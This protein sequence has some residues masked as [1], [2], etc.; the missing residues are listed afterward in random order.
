ML[1][2]IL[3]GLLACALLAFGSC[4]YTGMG[5][6]HT[7]TCTRS[8]R[9]CVLEA[10]TTLRF[11]VDDLTGAEVE[12]YR[13]AYPKAR[14]RRGASARLVLLTRRGRVGFMDFYSGIGMDAMAVQKAQVD[15]FVRQP[16]QPSLHIERDE[17]LLASV[18]GG[19]P[20]L[21]GLGCLVSAV[22]EYRRWWDA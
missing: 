11:S 7:L 3:R 10:E 8:D 15:A 21:L 2:V 22:V 4:A 13:T 17:R 5:K 6:V 12:D 9:L 16:G 18:L 20:F 14:G 19:I 1:G